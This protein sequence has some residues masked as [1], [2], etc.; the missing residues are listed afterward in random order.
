MP[1]R[2][3]SVMKSRRF[4]VHSIP[5]SQGRAAG[6]RM[7][8]DQSAGIAA[9]SKP[10]PASAMLTPAIFACPAAPNDRN[11]ST[12]PDLFLKRRH[13]EIGDVEAQSCAKRRL[14]K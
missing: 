6:Y 9:L 1:P 8:R 2:P 11:V 4:E 3:S 7:G 14:V 5:A 13:G 10:V 12:L